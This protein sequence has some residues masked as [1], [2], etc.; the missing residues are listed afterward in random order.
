ME[1][2]I[3]TMNIVAEIYKQV[4]LDGCSVEYYRLSIAKMPRHVYLNPRTNCYQVHCDH[5]KFQFSHLYE[6]VDDAIEKFLELKG[7]LDQQRTNRKG[8]YEKKSKNI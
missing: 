8:K 5:Y 2:T 1:R 7:Q 6:D 3:K 4:L